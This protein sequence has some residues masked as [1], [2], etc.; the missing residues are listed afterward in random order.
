[1]PA[2]LLACLPAYLRASPSAPNPHAHH[3]QHLQHLSVSLPPR[4]RSLFGAQQTAL[5]PSPWPSQAPVP[6]PAL[7]FSPLALPLPLALQLRWPPAG[8][9][10]HCPVPPL[11]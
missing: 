8:G 11:L 4:M 1:M 3:L 9:P 5:S 2:G 6:S 7:T 10:D